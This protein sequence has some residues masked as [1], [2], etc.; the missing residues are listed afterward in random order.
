[1]QSQGNLFRESYQDFSRA[2]VVRGFIKQAIRS[3]GSFSYN[4]IDEQGNLFNN[5]SFLNP[6]GGS[7][8]SFMIV[9]VFEG[10]EVYLLKT[11]PNDLPYII[12]TVFHPSHQKV[13]NFTNYT[14]ISK[15]VDAISKND[16]V[17]HNLDSQINISATN[18]LIFNSDNNIRMALGNEGC[19]KISKD[20]KGGD[21]ILNGAQFLLER[22]N[23]ID[24]LDA[25]IVKMEEHLGHLTNTVSAIITGLQSLGVPASASTPVVGS[26]LSL[27]MSTALTPN[28]QSQTANG[29]LQALPKRTTS[30][31]TQDC[32]KAL[33][34]RVIVPKTDTIG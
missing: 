2:K 32:A 26:A 13:Q 18:G 17:F 6:I 29:E 27:T 9:P 16:L 21:Y 22:K 15:E 25:K 11:I 12:G 20:G 7:H 1:M 31:H 30:A 24:E 34:K 28:S 23:Y 33:N 14:P 10:Q 5:V 19:F 4:V 3:G 8:N